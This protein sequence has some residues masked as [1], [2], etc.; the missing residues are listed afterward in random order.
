MAVIR[1]GQLFNFTG[2]S[3]SFFFLCMSSSGGEGGCLVDL[4]GLTAAA[5]AVAAG[6]AVAAC[7][8]E[9]D[10]VGLVGGCAGTVG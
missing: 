9:G 2:S 10:Q 8:G 5:V 6:A 1:G 3:S 4:T 7:E